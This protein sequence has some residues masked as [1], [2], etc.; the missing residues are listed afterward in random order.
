MRATPRL[1]ARPTATAIAAD[2]P[3]LI[4]VPELPRRHGR[5]RPAQVGPPPRRRLRREVRAAGLALLVVAGPV[6][7]AA[8]GVSQSRPWRWERAG[9]ERVAAERADAPEPALPWASV[10]LSL[11][12]EA[13][14][15]ERVGPVVCPA[16][17]LLPD[18]DAEEPRHACAGG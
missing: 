17:Y 5:R 13:T 8:W 2:V 14:A 4:Q 6:L 15:P 7:G 11:T 12:P 3:V 10:S 1:L 16:G 9:A 18:D